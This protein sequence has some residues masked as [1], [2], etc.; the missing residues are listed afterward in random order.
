MKWA[1]N[2]DFPACRP[3]GRAYG[4]AAR[5]NLYGRVELRVTPETAEA[6]EDGALDW[7]Q[8]T[9]TI[10]TALAQ[11]VLAEETMSLF[12]PRPREQYE[13]LGYPASK[14]EHDVFWGITAAVLVCIGAVTILVGVPAICR[15]ALWAGRLVR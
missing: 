4:D 1:G 9:S 15:A 14:V 13:V 3:F 2:D 6:I 12:D 8:L 5:M 11:S 7:S 10:N